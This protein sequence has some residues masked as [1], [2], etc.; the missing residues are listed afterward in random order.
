MFGS[1]LQIHSLGTQLGILVVV[2]MPCEWLHILP[3][4][5]SLSRN[6]MPWWNRKR[7]GGALNMTKSMTIPEQV[8]ALCLLQ[9]GFLSAAFSKCLA[10]IWR[11]LPDGGHGSIGNVGTYGSAQAGSLTLAP[12][13]RILLWGHQ[14]CSPVHIKGI[15]MQGKFP[16]KAAFPGHQINAYGS[17]IKSEMD[18]KIWPIFGFF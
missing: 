8:S 7:G 13:R 10:C 17:S 11:E 18:F 12:P 14:H 5:P 1:G 3:E 2:S 4:S 16:L 6:V 9:W 15:K